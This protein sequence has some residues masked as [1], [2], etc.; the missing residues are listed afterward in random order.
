MKFGKSIFVLTLGLFLAFSL[1]AGG[2]GQQSSGGKIAV[3]FAGTEG[4][5]TGQSRAM[6][7]IAEILNATGRFDVKV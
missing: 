2:R 6:M 3:T 5:T 4:E 7:E 1:F